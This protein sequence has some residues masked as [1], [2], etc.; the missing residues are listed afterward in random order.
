MVGQGS[1]CLKNYEKN[2]SEEEVLKTPTHLVVEE[3]TGLKSKRTG[4]EN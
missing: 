1:W 2:W 3:H 4:L